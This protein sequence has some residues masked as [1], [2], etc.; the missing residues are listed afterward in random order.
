MRTVELTLEIFKEEIK[1]QLK[2]KL[3]KKIDKIE[4]E[5][6]ISDIENDLMK[7]IPEFKTLEYLTYREIDDK[8]MDLVY[9][10]IDLLLELDQTIVVKNIIKYA[11]KTI[12]TSEMKDELYYEIIKSAYRRH[13]FYR[14]YDHTVVLM[15]DIIHINYGIPIENQIDALR[16]VLDDEFI[17]AGETKKYNESISIRLKYIKPGEI[18]EKDKT[19]LTIYNFYLIYQVPSF[20]YMSRHQDVCHKENILPL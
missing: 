19:Y 14:E 17:K 4:C 2:K 12:S 11:N 16:S 6:P 15:P 18:R 13:R 9:E 7:Y 8:E 20:S 1:I 3:K 5:K 10:N